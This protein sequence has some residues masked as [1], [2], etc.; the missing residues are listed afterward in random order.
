MA[1]VVW[2]NPDAAVSQVVSNL[3]T[4][5]GRDMVFGSVSGSLKAVTKAMAM[6]I[7]QDLRNMIIE[8]AY[9]DFT[10][11]QASILSHIIN[12]DI[13]APV[14]SGDGSYYMELTL[15]GDLTRPSLGPNDGAYDIV[16]LFIKGWAPKKK[17]KRPL[18]GT[19]HGMKVAAR[20]SKSGMGF[21]SEAVSYFNSKYAGTATAVLDSAYS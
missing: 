14:E 17:L 6:E 5:N 10:A 15:F 19:W 9:T 16:G 20:T 18:V 13:S 11:T 12:M 8:N 1:K 7:A 4:T 2:C 3:N 21:A